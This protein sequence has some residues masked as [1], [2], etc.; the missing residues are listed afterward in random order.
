MLN[1]HSLIV[2]GNLSFNFYEGEPNY[3]IT[4]GNVYFE[5]GTTSRFF[6]DGTVDIYGTINKLSTNSS[7]QGT[8]HLNNKDKIKLIAL[9]D[10]KITVSG[11]AAKAELAAGNNGSIDATDFSCDDITVVAKDGASICVGSPKIL[12][13]RVVDR[14]TIEHSSEEGVSIFGNSQNI[15]QAIMAEPCVCSHTEVVKS[16]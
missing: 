12:V 5:P 8:I 7:V 10:S 11:N 6:G 16:I 4:S 14:A 15:L 13:G 9:G 3:K 1:Y 2:A